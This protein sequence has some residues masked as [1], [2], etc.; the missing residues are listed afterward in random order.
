MKR[1]LCEH[2]NLALGPR[3]NI[4]TRCGGRQTPVTLALGDRNWH[5][6]G[7]LWSASLTEVQALGSVREPVSK[8]KTKSNGREHI[9]PSINLWP[10]TCTHDQAHR[11]TFEYEHISAYVLTP[12]PHTHPLHTQRVAG[13]QRKSGSVRSGY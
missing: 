8:T 9:I 10:P 13:R 11:H 5:I 1:L 6:L 3:Q 4:K 12:T 7:F 2:E